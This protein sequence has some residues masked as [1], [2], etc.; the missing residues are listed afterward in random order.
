MKEEIFKPLVEFLQKVP[1]VRILNVG[2]KNG[3]WWVKIVIDIK[4]SISWSII[5]E[6]GYVFNNISI[7]DKLPT[8]FY[9][10]SPPPY[11]NGGP[12]EYL[13]WIIEN[14]DVGF[15]PTL[16]KKWL[17]GRLPDPVDDLSSWQI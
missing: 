3:L 15:S 10:V 17:E 9:P 11:L 2:K 4:H 6:F 8:L 7:E 1:G 16:A 12:E 5:Q 13:S 14:T